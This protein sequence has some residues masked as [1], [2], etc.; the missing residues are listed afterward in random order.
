MTRQV[1]PPGRRAPRCQERKLLIARGPATPKESRYSHCDGRT[2]P[3]ASSSRSQALQRLV[4]TRPAAHRHRQGEA[5]EEADHADDQENLPDHL[6]VDRTN[7]AKVDG[8]GDDGSEG[9]E[10]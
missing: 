3:I 1:R 8:V 10:E 4:L 6:N 2:T 5:Q 9:D 7:L